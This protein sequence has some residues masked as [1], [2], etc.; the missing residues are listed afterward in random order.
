MASMV[1]EIRRRFARMAGAA[2]VA[3]SVWSLAAVSSAQGWIDYVDL[4][5]RFRINLPHEPAVEDSAFLGEYGDELPVRIYTASD[6]ISDYKV[7][8][9]DYRSAGVTEN[10]ASIAFQ[11]LQYRRRGGEVTHD[12]YA[13][14]DRIEGH[15]L[16]I[17]NPDQSRTFV[18]I[19]LHRGRLYVVEANAPPGAPPP[20]LVQQS[21]VM[22]DEYGNHV[23]YELD[24]DGNRAR[25]RT[26]EAD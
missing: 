7:S 19:H 9:I 24:A 21:L 11:A 14:I 2:I 13:Q 8:V 18:A 20:G 4:E 15:Q 10:R 23:R 3:V 26:V 17:T 1:M 12:A 16:Q 6:G 5:Q 25:A 22:L